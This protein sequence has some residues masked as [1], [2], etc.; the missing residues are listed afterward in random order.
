MHTQRPIPSQSM[1]DVMHPPLPPLLVSLVAERQK[2]HGETM[3]N[4]RC[5]SRI[6]NLSKNV[7][8]LHLFPRKT[9]RRS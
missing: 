2:K 1:P 6:P 3:D 8:L 4:E 7:S 9:M 5:S